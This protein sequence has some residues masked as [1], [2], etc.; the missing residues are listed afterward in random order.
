LLTHITQTLQEVREIRKTLDVVQTQLNSILKGIVQVLDE[1]KD[2]DCRAV[3][4]EVQINYLEPITSY[5]G[6]F[7]GENGEARAVLKS[8]QAGLDTASKIGWDNYNETAA[9]DDAAF[10]EEWAKEVAV[11]LP[12]KLRGFYDY[13]MGLGADSPILTCAK[14]GAARA[15]SKAFFGPLDD[16]QYFDFPLSLLVFFLGQQALGFKMI[17]EANIILATRAYMDAGGR[18]AAVGMAT[19][20]VCSGAYLLPVSDPSNMAKPYCD[21]IATAGRGEWSTPTDL[22]VAIL[23]ESFG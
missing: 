16:R 22:V 5:W 3:I 11:K 10:S 4:R 1:I 15:R 2:Q 13:L 6:R 7:T 21:N 19:Q 9:R 23:Y 17:L 8:A 20:G 14:V 12:G 18:N